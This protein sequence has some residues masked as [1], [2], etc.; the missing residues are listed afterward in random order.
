M[1]TINTTRNTNGHEMTDVPLGSLGLVYAELPEGEI[2]HTDMIVI[3]KTPQGAR[4]FVVDPRMV[5]HKRGEG[6]TPNH[7]AWQLLVKDST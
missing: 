4:V 1:T 2:G 5:P 6:T 7:A 3:C